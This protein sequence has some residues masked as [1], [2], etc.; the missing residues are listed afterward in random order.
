MNKISHYMLYISLTL[1]TLNL[2][3][4]QW[5]NQALFISFYTD[6]V[7][8]SN[9]NLLVIK[10][11]HCVLDFLL[12]LIWNHCVINK[13]IKSE[14]M[15]KLIHWLDHGYIWYCI[16]HLIRHH[17]N[18]FTLLVSSSYRNEKVNK[19]IHYL[20]DILISIYWVIIVKR[21]SE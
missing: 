12:G 8:G 11:R 13:L 5:Y 4:D 20:L 2:V 17:F 10:T 14:T 7:L 16:N 3:F 9:D 6:F 15:G 19:I 1:S 21:T 18:C